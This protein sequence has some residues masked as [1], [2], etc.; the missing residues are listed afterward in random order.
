MEE[1]E[2]FIG[3]QYGRGYFGKNHSVD[4]LWSEKFGVRLFSEVMPRHRF[5]EIKHNLRFDEKQTRSLRLNH[6]PFTHI[7]FIFDVVAAN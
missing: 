6:D 1:L 4:L 5:V 2:Q 7:R 3:L